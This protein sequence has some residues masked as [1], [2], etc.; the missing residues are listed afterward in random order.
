M[1]ECHGKSIF[2]EVAGSLPI[3]GGVCERWE[4]A[5][6]WGRKDT[7]SVEVNSVQG[8]CAT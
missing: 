6:G 4:S 1:K 3:Q 8:V 7:S 2:P 5:R